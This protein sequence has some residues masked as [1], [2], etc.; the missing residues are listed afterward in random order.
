MPWHPRRE[1][2]HSKNKPVASASRQRWFVQNSSLAVSMCT[3]SLL[4][5]PAG[6]L[7]HRSRVGSGLR[8]RRH[9]VVHAGPRF[10]SVVRRGS[11]RG[12]GRGGGWSQHHR[13]W[14]T[15][16]SSL[17]AAC[18]P[19]VHSIYTLAGSAISLSVPRPL[20]TRMTS[21]SARDAAHTKCTRA[22]DGGSWWDNRRHNYSGTSCTHALVVL[23]SQNV[24]VSARE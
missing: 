9:V 12:R 5:V 11:L 8:I 17:R 22:C 3:V 15:R 19:G 16:L 10:Q 1:Q 21:W 23:C 18:L 2:L 13:D 6:F 20:G 24:V 14:L 4:P 7:C